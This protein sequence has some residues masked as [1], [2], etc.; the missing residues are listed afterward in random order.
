VAVVVVLR[1]A[2]TLTGT[3]PLAD[4]AVAPEGTELNMLAVRGQRIKEIAVVTTSLA[5]QLTT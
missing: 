1:Q 3:A 4:P 2:L 5:L